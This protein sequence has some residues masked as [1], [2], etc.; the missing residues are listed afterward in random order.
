MDTLLLFQ[1]SIF[2]RDGDFTFLLKLYLINLKG[3]Q[4]SIMI[5]CIFMIDVRLILQLIKFQEKMSPL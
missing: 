5:K 1:L 3:Y 2:Q 4:I